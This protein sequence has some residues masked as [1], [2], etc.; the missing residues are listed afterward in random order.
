MEDRTWHLPILAY[1]PLVLS[2]AGSSHAQTG[3]NDWNAFDGG[4]GMSTG[5][6]Y[7]VRAS[8]GQTMV[9]TATLSGGPYSLTAGFWGIH[10]IQTPGA[11]RLSLER[12]GIDHLTLS[13]TPDAPGWVLQESMSLV[14]PNWMNSASGPTNNTT[15]ALP[16]PAGMK[17][18]RLFKP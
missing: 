17:F 14:S 16:G 12:S 13:W 6:L 11:P 9:N 2:L 3:G 4:G 10:V 1:V 15:V 7:S 5:G 18:Y 8:I